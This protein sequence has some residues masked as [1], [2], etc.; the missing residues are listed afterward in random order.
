MAT[1]SGL[2]DKYF[3]FKPTFKREH[4][5]PEPRIEPVADERDHDD[6]LAFVVGLGENHEACK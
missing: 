2:L 5:R 6:E 4:V 1:L 3:R